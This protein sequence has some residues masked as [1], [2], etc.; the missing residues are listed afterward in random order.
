LPKG[1]VRIRHFGFLANRFRASQVPLCRQLLE[2]DTPE[3][4]ALPNAGESSSTWHCPRCG[5]AMVVVQRL[6]AA[7]VSRCNYFDSS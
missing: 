7:E 5:A 3:E 4:P 6:T 2:V 1:F